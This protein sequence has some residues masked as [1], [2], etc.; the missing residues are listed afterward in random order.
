MSCCISN[1]ASRRDKHNGVNFASISSIC[2]ELP[3]KTVCDLR[4]PLMTFQ[5]D[6]GRATVPRTSI[7]AYE[8]M[9]LKE[10]ESFDENPLNR[11]HLLIFLLN[12]GRDHVTYLTLGHTHGKSEVYILYMFTSLSHLMNFKLNQVNH[13][14]T[15]T[16][17]LSQTFSAGKVTQGDLVN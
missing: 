14:K 2:A 13:T 6:F 1:D 17:I 16:M 12:Y 4:W 15:V 11:K 9:P 10:W 3:A 8:R 7:I 5:S